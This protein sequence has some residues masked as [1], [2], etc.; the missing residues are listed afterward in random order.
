M[1]DESDFDA[2][3]DPGTLPLPGIITPGEDLLSTITTLA[4]KLTTLVDKKND[5]EK[6]LEETNAAIEELSVRKLP[7]I[8]LGVGLNELRTRNGRIIK[9]TT[10]YF[11]KIPAAKKQEAAEWL[12]SHNMG[13]ILKEE[14]TVAPTEKAKLK[15]LG[16]EHTIDTSVHP[17]TLKALVREQIEAKNDFPRELFG[18]HVVDRVV[19]KE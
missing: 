14:I 8:L 11:A 9:V 5:L 15:L 19:V 18:V 6:H 12:R 2:T 7:T 4:T 10:D 16:I 17:S 1:S 13:S 3:E